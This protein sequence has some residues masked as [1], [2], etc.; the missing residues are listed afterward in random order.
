MFV[1]QREY[2]EEWYDR[3]FGIDELNEKL[4]ERVIAIYYSSSSGMGGPG[5]LRLLTEDNEQYEVG[6]DMMRDDPFFGKTKE[7][8][9]FANVV[10]NVPLLEPTDERAADDAFRYVY[11]AEKEG[12][13]YKRI[14]FGRYLV[15]DEYLD[16][17]D[18]E[19]VRR[20][21]DSENETHRVILHPFGRI[22]RYLMSKGKRPRTYI[23]EGT[24]DYRIY[25]QKEWEKYAAE[26]ERV[27]IRPEDVE[28]RLLWGNN[29]EYRLSDDKRLNYEGE[30]MMLFREDEDWGIIGEKW[31][32]LPQW[33]DRCISRDSEI[34]C[35]NLY[36]KEY[37][38]GIEG[39]LRHPEPSREANDE[40]EKYWTFTGY[41]VNDYGRFIFSHRTIEDAKEEALKHANGTIA[42]GGYNRENLITDYPS[43]E[44][45]E[46]L[47]FE[48]YAP[49][50]ILMEQPE[51]LIKLITEYKF[52]PNTAGGGWIK[53]SLMREMGVSAGMALN[54]MRIRLLDL[55]EDD[56]AF[57]RKRLKS[58]GRYDDERGLI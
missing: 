10:A 49:T 2:K 44:V 9:E 5:N 20:L 13:N 58:I 19:N 3:S 15:K 54:M 38:G 39:P 53:Q 51:K 28:W 29:F 45:E 1:N 14:M 52:L 35:Y 18:D 57:A 56:V 8:Y 27:R 4:L 41:E 21:M 6:M 12:W 37:E 16:V 48:K 11:R 26:R 47:I 55:H 40:H 17:D 22:G 31:T 46:R 24:R 30:F 25:L 42:Y 36:C 50:V 34:T 33:K 23:Y 43:K 7:N 32:I